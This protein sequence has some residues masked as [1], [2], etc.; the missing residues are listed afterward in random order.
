MIDKD[1]QKC[2]T[3]TTSPL[4][5]SSHNCPSLSCK[6]TFEQA[7]MS[8]CTMVMGISSAEEKIDAAFLETG[9]V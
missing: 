6:S 2:M 3:A 9:F 8:C 1:G 7:W 5:Y 4:F